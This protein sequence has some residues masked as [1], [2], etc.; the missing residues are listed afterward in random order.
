M[1]VILQQEFDISYAL[2]IVTI[3]AKILDKAFYEFDNITSYCQAY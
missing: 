2:K 3:A 1:W